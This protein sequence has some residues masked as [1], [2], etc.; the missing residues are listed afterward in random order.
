MDYKKYVKRLRKKAGPD[1][2][3]SME[4][5]QEYLSYLGI[6]IPID[7]IMESAEKEI[8]TLMPK[9]NKTIESIAGR[10]DI[11]AA[12][13]KIYLQLPE[14]ITLKWYTSLYRDLYSMAREKGLPLAPKDSVVFVK[15]PEWLA[16]FHPVFEYVPPTVTSK[17]GILYLTI[18]PAE[19]YLV[20]H[21]RSAAIYM[22]VRKLLGQHAIE[23]FSVREGKIRSVFASKATM[24]GWVS[25]VLRKLLIE[26]EIDEGARLIAIRDSIE[27]AA[28]AIADISINTG[29]MKP[30]DCVKYLESVGL[31]SRE[32]ALKAIFVLLRNPAYYSSA[33]SAR[34]I[35][36]AHP[37]DVIRKGA[38]PPSL[39]V[40][41]E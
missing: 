17:Q 38:I 26:N 30:K 11:K 23:Y 41:E 29:K 3:V 18:P 39:L 8:E 36:E 16:S 2:I 6:N 14:E 22:I 15:T 9:M 34:L 5:Y 4:E 28:L 32:E 21:S 35:L 12:Y 1:P 24:D 13:R 19:R 33:Y 31:L 7:T 40:G 25:I 10:N 37:H 20:H 27:S